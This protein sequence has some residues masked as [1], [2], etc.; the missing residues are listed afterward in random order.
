MI[1]VRGIE[2]WPYAPKGL[3]CTLGNFDGVHRG[4]TALVRATRA[5]AA[6]HH[7]MSAVITF[8]PAPR[9]V[10]RPGN[11]IPRIQSLDRKLLHL[12]RAGIDATIVEPFDA[13]LAALSPE[14]FAQR[15]SE[16]LGIVAAAVGHDFRFGHKRMGTPETLRQVLGIEVREIEA[17]NDDGGPISSSRVREALST[18]DVARATRLLGRP[19][20]LVGRVIPGD[21]RGRTLGFPTA[22]L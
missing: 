7:T 4:H 10:L 16:K 14:A 9:D 13:A 18:G 6:E 17:L 12:E 2:R 3:V 8:D 15:L 20:E 1:V 19:H 21:Q 11:G 22:N 5:L